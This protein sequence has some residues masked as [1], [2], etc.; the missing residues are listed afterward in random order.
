MWGPD[1]TPANIKDTQGDC[2]TEQLSMRA[3]TNKREMG[4]GQCGVLGSIP[5][6]DDM[7]PADSRCR[8]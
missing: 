1:S 6:G 8:I 2:S 4:N 7:Q 5:A 3:D